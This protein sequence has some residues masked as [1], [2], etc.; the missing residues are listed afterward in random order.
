[1][2]AAT[3]PLLGNGL[4]IHLEVFSAQWPAETRRGDAGREDLR[5]SLSSL[6]TLKLQALGKLIFYRHIAHV[7][8]KVVRKVVFLSGKPI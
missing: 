2:R 5:G 3:R 8:E 6:L 1:M 4:H 7:T